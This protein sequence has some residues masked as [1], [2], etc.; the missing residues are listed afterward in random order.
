M[1]VPE[2]TH[3]YPVPV[4]VLTGTQTLTLFRHACSHGYAL[5][6][7][8]VTSSSTANAVLEAARDLK[9]PIIIQL[10]NGGAAFFAGKSLNNANQEASIAGSIAAAHHIRAMAS[11]YGVSVVL[12]SDHCARKL[13]PWLD[14]M[15]EADEKHFE[16]HGVPLFS[17]HMI[18]LSEESDADN[19]RTCLDYMHKLEKIDCFLEMEIG[20]TG[21]EEDGVNNE[22]ADTSRLYTQPEQVWE[23]YLYLS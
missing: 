20:I 6:A 22:E 2:K 5:P 21:G 13:L 1:S 19:I 17:S 12:H 8:N 14:G 11:H 23:V 18:D 3:G 15:I 9:V 4:G 16:Q 10:S 7:V